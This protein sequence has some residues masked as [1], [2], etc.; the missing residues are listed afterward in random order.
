VVTS[1]VEAHGARVVLMTYAS[2][3]FMPR[4][5]LAFFPD[6]HPRAVGYKLIARVVAETLLGMASPSPAPTLPQP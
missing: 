1:A 2:H 5:A 4:R 3:G 6:M